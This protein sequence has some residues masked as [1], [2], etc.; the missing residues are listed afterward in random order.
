MSNSL[1][2]S[3]DELYE[4]L[5]DRDHEAAKLHAQHICKVCAELIQSLTDEIW[6]KNES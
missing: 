2:D 4:D 5:M 3:V 6:E 1:H